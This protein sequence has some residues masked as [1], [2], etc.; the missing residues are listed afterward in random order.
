MLTEYLVFFFT[1]YLPGLV[2]CK[3]WW[4]FD[5]CSWMCLED[6]SATIYFYRLLV[7]KLIKIKTLMWTVYKHKVR[8]VYGGWPRGLREAGY[9]FNGRWN[10]LES[11][12]EWNFILLQLINPYKPGLNIGLR[13]ERRLWSKLMYFN[14]DT[15][16]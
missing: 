14:S 10:Y 6:L 13:S 16:I 8:C 5:C 4:Y 7:V 1:I 12:E 11:K 9:T 2:F 15:R 3:K